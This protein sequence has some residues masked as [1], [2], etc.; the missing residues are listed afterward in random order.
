M[1]ISSLMGGLGN[2]L[3]QY[4]AGR[5]LAHK[6]GTQLKLDTY[7]LDRSPHRAYCLNNFNINAERVTTR[8]ILR[9]DTTEGVLRILKS[10]SPKAHS[11]FYIAAQKTRR[12]RF[13]TRYYEYELGT[14]LPP[15]L[16][17][18]V[19]S[20]RLFDFDEDFFN[21][22]DDI[23][24]IGTWVSYK[25]FEHIKP[26]LLNEFSVKHEL[27]GKEHEMAH[28]IKNTQSV[29]V[30]VRRTD[31][32]SSQVYFATDLEYIRQAM[33]FFYEKLENPVFYVFSDDIT[34]CKENIQKKNAV[35]VDWNDDAH[36]YEDLRLMS[37]CKHNIIAESSFSW[38]GA[39]LNKNQRKIVITPPAL[40]WVSRKN[41]LCK[42]ILP[43]EWK[44][45]E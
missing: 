19:A 36:S 22:P 42:D 25:Y 16:V 2:Q 40:R 30:H 7:A 12:F 43:P 20:Q 6:H 44:V 27:L 3:F 32:V 21:L 14:P 5:A 26:I 15:L 45:F 4:A 37:L 8:D 13:F 29:S 33:T 31:K 41:S 23:V 1:I 18:R 10:L 9:L 17:K 35:F 39:Y 24:L 34:W 38:W 11:V 28:Q